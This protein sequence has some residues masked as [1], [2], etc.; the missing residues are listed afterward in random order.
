MKY[1]LPNKY[2]GYEG[3]KHG[4]IDTG[5]TIEFWSHYPGPE[6]K[7]YSSWEDHGKVKK[8]LCRRFIIGQD[9]RKGFCL[10]WEHFVTLEAHP[11]LQTPS[12]EVG[13]FLHVKQEDLES[14]RVSTDRLTRSPEYM[15]G[16]WY[17]VWMGVVPH[18]HNI[19]RLLAKSLHIVNRGRVHKVQ[20]KESPCSIKVIFPYGLYRFDS[21]SK[22]IMNSAGATNDRFD[23][24]MLSEED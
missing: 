14:M 22:L 21:E 3:K 7:I 18:N 13:V 12:P 23:D 17:R 24:L 9:N 10:P 2:H 19:H 4:I 5:S 16:I 8:E 15:T 20:I 6:K 11:W 1:L